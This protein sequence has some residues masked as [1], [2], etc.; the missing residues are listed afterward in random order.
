MKIFNLVS[1]LSS[2]IIL[3]LTGVIVSQETNNSKITLGNEAEQKTEHIS[4]K[5][6]PISKQRSS[7]LSLHTVNDLLMKLDDYN[8]YEEL[9]SYAE[10]YRQIALMDAESIQAALTR[11][12]NSK[13]NYNSYKVKDMLYSKWADSKPQQALKFMINLDKYK[14]DE[15]VLKIWY[16]NEPEAAMLWLKNNFSIKLG[17][18]N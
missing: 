8:Y 6:T 15:S 1:R 18:Y 2:L 11:V 7:R 4:F 17:N 12:I 14:I 16:K 5:D 13:K 3:S 9:Q 10:L